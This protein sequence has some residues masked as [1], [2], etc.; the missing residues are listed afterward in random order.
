MDEGGLTKTEA[1][2][3]SAQNS[4]VN[5]YGKDF[6]NLC[7]NNYLGLAD[8]PKLLQS[9]KQTLEEF[10]FCMASV[11]FICGTSTLHKDLEKT[12]S[13]FIGTEDCILYSSCFDANAGLF[14]TCWGLKTRS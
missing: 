8:H 7:S 12:V 4:S 6:I 3:G 1:P 14:E 9:G 11:R 2:I 13:E 5:I 10:G